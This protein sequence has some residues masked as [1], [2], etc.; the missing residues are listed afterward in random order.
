[1][2]L[3]MLILFLKQVADLRWVDATAPSL[4]LMDGESLQGFLHAWVAKSDP[5]AGGSS[6]PSASTRGISS[7]L[8][9]VVSV[10]VRVQGGR[11]SAAALKTLSMSY[12]AGDGLFA[13]LTQQSRPTSHTTS[14]SSAADA[15][16]RT[17]FCFKLHK[18]TIETRKTKEQSAQD[19]GH[20]RAQTH[21]ASSQSPAFTIPAIRAAGTMR[22]RP[23]VLAAQLNTVTQNVDNNNHRGTGS[24]VKDAE[25]ESQSIPH[26]VVA[27]S[28]GKC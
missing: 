21:S 20:R 27:S 18:T 26:S 3:R 9:L 10:V 17:K 11:A 23:E 16:M 24:G 12:D 7:R 5:S 19:T 14:S 6:I 8:P 1:M 4:H 22:R 28:S 25:G 13:T 2:H 15:Q